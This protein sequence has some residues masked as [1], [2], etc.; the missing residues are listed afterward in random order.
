MKGFGNIVFLLHKE[1]MACAMNTIGEIQLAECYAFCFEGVHSVRSPIDHV[2]HCNGMIASI[3][4][5]RLA[6]MECLFAIK[7][8]CNFS[9]GMGNPMIIVGGIG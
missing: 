5:I 1:C 7:L 4:K 8:V 3:T 6:M 9:Y 2:G